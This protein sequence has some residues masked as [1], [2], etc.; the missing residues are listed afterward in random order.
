MK[1]MIAM[2]LAIVMVC[3]LSV[4]VFAA[5][6]TT[7]NGTDS[8]T[9]YGTYV[10]GAQAPEYH[11]NV[12]WGTM[13]FVYTDNAETWDEENHKWVSSG[14]AAWTLAE[15]A[16]NTIKITSNSSA[17]V[18]ATLGFTAGANYT[19]VEGVFTMVTENVTFANNAFTLPVAAESAAATEY[20]LTFMPSKALA[21]TVTTEAAIG[22]ITVELS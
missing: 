22:T 10:A 17:E 20:N 9:V 19:G 2:L 12:T 4:S 14:D 5:D 1:K 3:A 15:G 16:T 21:N 18:T 7:A 6:I 8:A 11:V 13:K